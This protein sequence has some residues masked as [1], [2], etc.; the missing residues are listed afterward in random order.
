MVEQ[1]WSYM[2]QF[3]AAMI[4][5]GPTFTRDGTLTGSLHILDLPDPTAA[6]TFAFEEPC[7]QAGAYRD[8]LLRRWHNDLG[9]TMRD[10][11]GSRAENN[12][13]L[14]LGFTLEPAATAIELPRRDEM[15]VS[16]PLLSD[17]GSLV[18]G[19]A[20][21]LEAPDTDE[22]RIVL[23]ADRYTGIEVHQWRFGGRPD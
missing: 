21:L 3:A 12:R 2:D 14:V 15:M 19:A 18:L 9:R 16:G 8:V 17:D 10:F 1:H 7:Y 11:R 22:A 5:R 4:V 20:V 6:R 13:Y 23:P